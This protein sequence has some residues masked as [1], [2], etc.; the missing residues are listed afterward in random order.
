[1]LH[2]AHIY[3]LYDAEKVKIRGNKQVVRVAW[4]KIDALIFFGCNILNSIPHGSKNV[5]TGQD[6][7]VADCELY[8][9]IWAGSAA[10]RGMRGAVVGGLRHAI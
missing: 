1:M 7:K 8:A 6:W 10:V 9:S 4:L 2:L 5:R 3:T